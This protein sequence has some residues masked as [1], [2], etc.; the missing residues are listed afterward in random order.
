MEHHLLVIELRIKPKCKYL[1]H[2]H[3]QSQWWLLN[4]ANCQALAAAIGDKCVG[5][6]P[7]YDHWDSIHIAITGAVK[8][9]LGI[10]TGGYNCDNETWRWNDT[11]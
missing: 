6:E 7:I 5:V 3:H 4:R 1:E 10:F 11:V 2:C 8:S 9:V